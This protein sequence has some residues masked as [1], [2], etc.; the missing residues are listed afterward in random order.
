MV[1][2][3]G[4]TV[5]A[6]LEQTVDV[7]KM[8]VTE[9]VAGLWKW[10]KDKIGDLEEMVIGGIKNFIIEKVIKA[11]ITWLISLLNPAAA[12]I[13]ACKAIYDIVMFFIERGAQIMDFVNSMLDSI[14]AIAKRQHRRVAEKVEDALAK[15][16]PLAICFLASLLGLGGISEKIRAIIEKVRKPITKAVDFVV[17]GAVKGAKKLF[18]GAASGSRASTRRASSGSRTR[19]P[20]ARSGRGRSRGIKDRV[21]G[22]DEDEEDPAK[23]KGDEPAEDV[24]EGFSMSGKPHTLTAHPEGGRVKIIM[25]SDNPDDLIAKA[26]KARAEAAKAGKDVSPPTSA[27]S[28]PP[29]TRRRRSWTSTRR[30]RATARTRRRSSA[31]ARFAGSPASSSRSAPS[32]RSTT[33][34]SA[35]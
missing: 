2:L 7:F 28:S 34:S 26:E 5:V 24:E 17:M 10:I 12:F 4:E 23:A 29:P 21:T 20:P 15:A 35:S 16:L 8:L 32:T 13:K 11:G 14:G 30:T 19:P 3:V 33:S 1:K 31:T 25:A 9:G 27:S 6:K 18:G 22:G